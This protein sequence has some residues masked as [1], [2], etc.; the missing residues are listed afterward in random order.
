V[1]TYRVPQSL[2][3]LLVV[4]SVA[5]G[6]AGRF[7]LRDPFQADTDLRS[8]SVPCRADPTPK[9]KDHISCAPQEY[10]SP[11]NWDGMDNLFF[12]PF[13]ELWTFEASQEAPNAN[14]IDEV[15]DSAWFTNR[16]GAH[17]MSMEELTHGAC[18]PSQFI[19][20]PEDAPD[21]SWVIDHGKD[22][23][24]SQGFR[25]K[26]AG[27]GKF[28]LKS[29]APGV[30]RSTAASA[31]G[32]AAYNAVGF[33]TTCEQVVYVKPSVFKLTPG[34][35]VTNNTGIT[36]PFDQAALDKVLNGANKK[37][38]YLRFSAS[39]WLEGRLIGP[40]R[41]EKT[42]SDDPNDVL[43]HQDRRE[44]RGGRLLA[45]WLDH[46]DAR[47]QNSMD[48]WFADRKDQPESS[49]GHVIHYYLDTSDILGSEWDWPQISRRLGYSY[50]LDWSD[51]GRDFFTLGIPTRPWDEV[52]L[53]PGH[54][55]FAYFNLKNFVPDQWKN[56]YPNP[57]FSRMTE[58][59]AAWMARILA[60]FTPE[61]VDALA[62]MGQ[63]SD[64]SNASY[65]A[66][67]LEG[68]LEKILAR[69]LT[70]LSPLADL[71][72]EDDHLLCATDLAAKRHVRADS[73][74]H[75][76]AEDGHRRPLRVEQGAEGGICVSVTHEAPDS[77]SPDTDASRY[78]RV[79]IRDGVAKGPLVAHLYDLGPKRGFRLVGIQRP[80]G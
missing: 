23:G 8:V 26:I 60:R 38:E 34:L 44:L 3:L 25:I 43:P 63:F 67:V 1:K 21:G 13:T 20:H 40:F 75:Y 80:D 77:G 33:F 59:D 36:H 65:V 2:L 56:E 78:A 57:A 27:K 37:G 70:R 29:D 69:Y 15:A 53:V 71:H 68:R 76:S 11:L 12:R 66:E 9:D 55:I 10:V 22:N 46:F 5:C 7:A 6:G 73:V 74:F 30:E 62:K 64:P 58:R 72:V 51:V 39:A 48:I 28:L 49:P 16:L 4:L 45:A 35:K 50:V 14:S 42:R 31:I 19:E 47:E 24:A 18:T 32:A 61:M 79:S 41:Y 52:Q 54:E 17:P